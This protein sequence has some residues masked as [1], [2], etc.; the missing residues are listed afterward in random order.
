MHFGFFRPIKDTFPIDGLVTVVVAWL[1]L[2]SLEALEGH[3]C[4]ILDFSSSSSYFDLAR[5]LVEVEA[6][7]LP[8]EKNLLL[9]LARCCMLPQ[10]KWTFHEP[11]LPLRMSN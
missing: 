1:L 2:G 8:Q 11:N 4:S 10:I 7:A 9:L 6:E 5:V 3:K